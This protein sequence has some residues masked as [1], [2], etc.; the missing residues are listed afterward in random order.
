MLLLIALEVVSRTPIGVKYTFKVFE[1]DYV[2]Y[3]QGISV[4]LYIST[5]GFPT[6]AKD[7][8]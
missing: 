8:A 3:K 4:Y 7:Y 6:A 2:Q 1:S 5:S